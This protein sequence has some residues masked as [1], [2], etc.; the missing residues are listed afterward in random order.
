MG[1]KISLQSVVPVRAGAP[2][3]DAAGLFTVSRVADDLGVPIDAVVAL[4]AGQCSRAV[5]FTEVRGSVV[6]TESGVA[7]V[8][9][10][11]EARMRADVEALDVAQNPVPAAAQTSQTEELKVTRVFPW[12]AAKKTTSSNVLAE[13]ANG[14]EVVLVVR[15]VTHLQPGMVLAGCVRGEN[16][17]Y[18]MGRL[19]RSGGERQLFFPPASTNRRTANT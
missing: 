15:D 7:H 18:Y 10:A 14:N 2:A 17:W 16:A 13:R 3:N 6:F 4:L 1:K 12:A 9:A 19:P 8:R 5:H 11:I